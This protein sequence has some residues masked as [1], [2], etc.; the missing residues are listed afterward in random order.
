MALVAKVGRLHVKPD[1]VRLGLQRV[2]D[3]GLP[4]DK[5]PNEPGTR[6]PVY[7]WRRARD[8]TPVLVVANCRS[9]DRFGRRRG[10]ERLFNLHQAGG[11]LR[12]GRTLE[13]ID[14]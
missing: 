5:T 8:P 2:A 6:Q 3:D 9:R 10:R 13:V 4:I 12:T 7:M 1:F 14:L 11:D